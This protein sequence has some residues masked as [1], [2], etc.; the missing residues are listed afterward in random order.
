MEAVLRSSLD[1][2]EARIVA[3]S[4][5]SCAATLF[6]LFIDAA[7]ACGLTATPRPT[8]SRLAATLATHR[9]EPTGDS[10]AV[11]AALR[12][13]ASPLHPDGAPSAVVE[14]AA[15]LARAGRC[16]L[17]ARTTQDAA[18]C[19]GDALVPALRATDTS[20]TGDRAARWLARWERR[21]AGS[22]PRALWD[23]PR[24][25]CE[26]RLAFDGD[27]GTRLVVTIP[28]R[29]FTH[30][31]P[32]ILDRTRAGRLPPMAIVPADMLVIGQVFKV[33]LP[34]GARPLREAFP[35]SM[36]AHLALSSV[37]ALCAATAML[38]QRRGHGIGPISRDLA[39]FSPGQILLHHVGLARAIRDHRDCKHPMAELPHAQEDLQ[40]RASTAPANDVFHL[41]ALLVTLLFGDGCLP[42]TLEFATRGLGDDELPLETVL[43]QATASVL[44]RCLRPSPERPSLAE[45]TEAIEEATWS[46]PAPEGPSEE[47][48]ERLGARCRE[49][50]T[51]LMDRLLSEGERDRERLVARYRHQALADLRLGPLSPGAEPIDDALLQHIVLNQQ[52]EVVDDRLHRACRDD[53][54]PAVHE[55]AARLDRAFAVLRARGL[56]ARQ[57][58][59]ESINDGLARLLDDTRDRHLPR[60]RGWV[61]YSRAEARECREYGTLHLSYG[62]ASGD[63]YE[64]CVIAGEVAGA[65]R[66]EG[67]AVEWSGFRA[68]TVV[69]RGF[70]AIPTASSKLSA[71]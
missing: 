14:A 7:E 62:A 28:D 22:P 11:L 36:P 40:G 9:L 61:L 49:L 3:L 6:D 59:G 32:Q 44:R 1:T 67:L 10:L 30:E 46:T 47:A 13:G 15:C 26:V 42:R 8:F 54:G 37:H 69:I 56:A 39:A 29:A 63:P 60:P 24:G 64:A 27:F 23:E 58:L 33:D 71:P 16:L 55:H 4:A 70:A 31:A 17:E 41:A 66:D 12:D 21:S 19:L 18:C 53:A 2:L 38:R 65:L 43:P 20:L 5:R 45:L 35:D 34:A 68:D 48:L 57:D 51:S 52:L 25:L 50:G